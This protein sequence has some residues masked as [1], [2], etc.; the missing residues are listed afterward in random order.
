MF[1]SSCH[2]LKGV[3]RPRGASLLAPAARMGGSGPWATGT[4]TLA[5]ALSLT[6]ARAPP[7][8]G[9]GDPFAPRAVVH[10]GRRGRQAGLRLL[11]HQS[12][13]Q[14]QVRRLFCHVQ[15]GVPQGV[16]PAPTAP[17]P[18][19]RGLPPPCLFRVM[20]YIVMARRWAPSQR[21]IDEAHFLISGDI[22][23]V[24][25][26]NYMGHNYI[27]QAITIWAITI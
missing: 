18:P 10:G 25:G 17:L 13:P 22:R 7:S 23:A 9:G 11:V 15:P 6:C 5:R 19:P 24:R 2:C 27:G 21:S 1:I 26:H 20:A 8:G 14:G 3:L 4:I 12:T 16:S